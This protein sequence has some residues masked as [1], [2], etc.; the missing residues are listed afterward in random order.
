M[1]TDLFDIDENPFEPYP[2]SFSSAEP[3]VLQ[4]P[5]NGPGLPTISESVQQYFGE[6]FFQENMQS[7]ATATPST[8]CSVC[9]RDGGRIAIL[10]PCDHPLCSGCLTS[11]LNIVG[12]KAMQCAVCRE[13]VVDFDLQTLAS[14]AN[15]VI[16]SSTPRQ[17]ASPSNFTPLD[18]FASPLQRRTVRPLLPSFDR[19]LFAPHMDQPSAQFQRDLPPPS[20]ASAPKQQRADNVVLRIDNVPWV[21]PCIFGTPCDVSDV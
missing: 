4:D 1:S 6:S 12:E 15:P 21:G 2:Q 5:F 14:D 10:K 9:G 16:S 13:S 18:A 7:S 20:F 3:F 17:F 8:A 19:I 11:A